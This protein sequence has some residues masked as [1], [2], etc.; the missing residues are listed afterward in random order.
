[1][2]PTP[3]NAE[4][5]TPAT[6]RSHSTSAYPRPHPP[7]PDFAQWLWHD[8]LLRSVVVC[9]SLLLGAQLVLTLLHPSWIGP[10]TDWLLTALTWPE[11]A[12]VIYA[13]LWLHHA[14]WAGALS[15]WRGQCG[16]LTSSSSSTTTSRSPASP[17]WCSRS[18]IPF[19]S[20]HSS[21]SHAHVW[22]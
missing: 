17:T 22:Q 1:M 6:P 8:R 7:Q 4:L 21:S 13:T 19:S 10:V 11:L 2:N 5:L 20:R 3:L 16:R 18:N 15:W 14:H 9:C 12:V